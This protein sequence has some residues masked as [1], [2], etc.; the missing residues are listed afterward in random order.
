VRNRRRGRFPNRGKNLA[1]LDPLRRRCWR[2]PV[3]FGSLRQEMAMALDVQRI[4]GTYAKVAARLCNFPT[5]TAHLLRAHQEFLDDE[6]RPIVRAMPGHWIDMFGYASRIGDVSFNLK[7]SDQ[8]IN[9]VKARI[10]EYTNKVNFQIHKALGETESGPRERDN[11]GYYR[12]VEIYVYAN[13]PAPTPVPPTP[14]PTLRRVTARSFSKVVPEQDLPSS[15]A[16]DIA[17]DAINTLLKLGIAAAQGKLTAEGLLGSETSRQ[18]SHVPSD[19]RVNKMIT[20]Q[21]VSYD[22]FVGGSVT[23]VYTTITYE[24]G[25]PTPHVVVE[26]R[27]QF[28]F[29]NV[30]HPP[31]NETRLI[32][33]TQAESTPLVVPPD[34]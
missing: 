24:W 14:Q 19:H 31:S 1:G 29:N 11:S 9:A 2:S 12:A 3:A 32:P 25:P 30:V 22:S 34:P 5:A 26:T 8:R 10:E 7:L 4:T 17:K 28:T 6:V 23:Q 15:G 33:R 20:D 13:K 16:P 18:V 21:K 27:Y